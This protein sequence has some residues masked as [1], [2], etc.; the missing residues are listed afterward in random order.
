MATLTTNLTLDE[1]SNAK[2]YWKKSHFNVGAILP[3][4]G[5]LLTV[6]LVGN[7]LVCV[8]IIRNKRMRTRW[9]YLLMNLSIADMGFAIATPI[10]L[11][12]FVNIDIGMYC[13]CSTLLFVALAPFSSSRELS[14]LPNIKQQRDPFPLQ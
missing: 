6:C 12:Q 9:Y 2:N 3:A 4:Y 5:I 10:Q 13:L 1:K 8:T 14:L 11:L 7:V